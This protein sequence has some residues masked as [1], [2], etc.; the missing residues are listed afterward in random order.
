MG[1]LSDRKGNTQRKYP[2]SSVKFQFYSYLYENSQKASSNFN[3][4][5]RFSMKPNK[6]PICFAYDCSSKLK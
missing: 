2:V 5:S 4:K 3:F 1:H 6:F